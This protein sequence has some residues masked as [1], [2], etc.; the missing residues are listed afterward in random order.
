MD[1]CVINI[2][3]HVLFLCL[4]GFFKISSLITASKCKDTFMILDIQYHIT[5]QNSK[6]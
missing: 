1:K 2:F 3:M 6:I 4:R 5:F